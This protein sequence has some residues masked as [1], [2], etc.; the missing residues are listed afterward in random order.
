MPTK[1]VTCT[2]FDVVRIEIAGEARA[3]NIPAAAVLRMRDTQA[4]LLEVAREYRLTLAALVATQRQ[5]GVGAAGDNAAA[6][7][8]VEAL[9][10]R[11]EGRAPESGAA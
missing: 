8:R 6:L 4:E 3:L 10:A 5:Y 1:M 11:A 7:A 2:N 9:L